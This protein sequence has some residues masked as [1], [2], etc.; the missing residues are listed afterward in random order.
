MSRKS[1]N[2]FRAMAENA[3]D[4]IVIL[5]D[6]GRACYANKRAC[7][8]SGYC[9]SEL[10]TVD[11]KKVAPQ[12][13]F[14][15]ALK[16]YR[17][18][19]TGEQVSGCIE[20]RFIH[21]RGQELAIELSAST[22]VWDGKP[23]VLLIFRD[24][25]AR[26]HTEKMLLNSCTELKCRIE[27]RDLELKKAVRELESRRRELLQLKIEGEKINNELLE[28]NNAISILA[29]TINKH[30]LEAEKTFAGTINSKIIPIIADLRKK[31]KLDDLKVGLDILDAHLQTLSKELMGEMNTLAKLTP[32]EMLIATMIKSGLN[33]REIGEKFCISLQTVKTHRRNI[34]KKLNIRAPGAGLKDYLRSVMD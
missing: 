7:D 22:T 21:K 30:R 11:F 17:E 3:H 27:K 15:N 10:A 34:R 32:S 9:S 24:I 23:A 14:H 28:T 16:K 26:V 8:I 13:D 33:S 12:D 18:K 19:T 4:A 31:A 2:N 25:T 20:T 5:T 1:E 6:D 29:G